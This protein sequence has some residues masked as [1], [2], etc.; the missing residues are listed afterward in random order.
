MSTAGKWVRRALVTFV[1][2][3]I[4]RKLSRA[5][6]RRQIEEE[7]KANRPRI[8]DIQ[9]SGIPYED[10]VVETSKGKLKGFYVPEYKCYNF[11]GV[12]FAEPPTGP[13]RFRKPVPV[14]RS[15]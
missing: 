3:Y 9:G 15:Q 5:R 14:K 7:R 11:R 4:L 10:V 1:A 6:L 12:P 2:W 13:L 8:S